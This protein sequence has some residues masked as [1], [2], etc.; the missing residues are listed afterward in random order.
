MNLIV[1]NSNFSFVIYAFLS[2]IIPPHTLS[3]MND[4]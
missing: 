3:N 2:N 4:S 1:S